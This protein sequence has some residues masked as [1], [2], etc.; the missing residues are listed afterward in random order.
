MFS[1]KEIL[2][3]VDHT[4]LKPEATW[5]EVKALCDEGLWGGVASLCLSPCHVKAAADYVE[6][7]V[8][9]CTVIGFPHG[10]QT[11]NTK[12]FETRE[13]AGHGAAEIDMVIAL[14]LTKA[15]DWEAA[16]AEIR[17]VKEACGGAVLKV[18]IEACLLTEPEKIRLCQIV[19]RAG[20]E[21]IKTSTGFSTGG[22]TVEDVKLFRRHIDPQVKI[23]AAGGIRTWAAAEEFLKAGADRLGS[24][25]LVPLAKR[26]ELLGTGGG[27]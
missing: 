19:S 23:K 9:I 27:N 25:A 1:K 12:V 21:F 4:L 13:A 6:G 11:G 8:P 20:A 15:G 5:E 16:L 10:T 17:A 3:R 14:G 22:A 7:R 26:E 2:A 18:I 24:S